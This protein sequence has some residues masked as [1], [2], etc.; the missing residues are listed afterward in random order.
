MKKPVVLILDNSVDLTGALKSITR[1]SFDLKAYFDFVFVIPKKSR[2]RFWM[3]RNGFQSIEEL[4]LKEINKQ[5]LQL[6][7]YIPFLLM[8]AIRLRN[9]IK[10]SNVSLLHV[11]DIYNLL[12]VVLNFFGSNVSYVCHVRFLPD[13]FPT[14]L[15]NFWL[16]AHLR[17]AKKIVVV[18]KSV[19]N[20]LPDHPKFELI[21]NEIPLGERYPDELKTS[22][23]NEFVFLY[24]SNFIEGKGQNFALEAFANIHTDLPGWKLRFVGGDMG[25]LK[26]KQYKESLQKRAQELKILEKTEWQGF[27]EDVEKEYRQA[28][29]V[30]NFSES[31][32]F[33]I[34]CA[35][36][37][38]FGKPLIATDC[39]G[40]REIVDHNE[41]G[42]IVPN[43]N[44]AGMA[45][46]MK[47]L[48]IN[49]TQREQMAQRAKISVRTRFS[50][51][52]TSFRL[53]SVYDA[54]LSEVNG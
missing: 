45:S 14:W 38:F 52:N 26:N 49:E 44:V 11:N 34:T 37:L 8:N 17:Y 42:L 31:E 25:L 35:E 16:K 28:D 29:I 15:F 2:G 40:P 54:A 5:I 21:Y 36:A 53:K 30:L 46:A 3:E 7:V 48:A 39:G 19:L 24:L 43:R 50:I 18:S 22:S 32:S 41:T 12:P 47:Q 20:Q 1:T 13:R 6:L 10:R 27:T 51:E 9:I 33:S 23:T 4:P